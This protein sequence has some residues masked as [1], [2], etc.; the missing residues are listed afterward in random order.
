MLGFI[1]LKPY[2]LYLKP[3][4]YLEVFLRGAEAQK[5]REGIS[6]GRL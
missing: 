3:L 5:R 6:V 4:S 1:Y 2:T